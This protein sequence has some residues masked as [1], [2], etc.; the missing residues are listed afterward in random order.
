MSAATINLGRKDWL[1]YAA[2]HA[3]KTEGALNFFRA[4]ENVLSYAPSLFSQQSTLD[5]LSQLRS[6]ADLLGAALSFP[7]LFKN[8]RDLRNHFSAWT[9]A[10]PEEGCHTFNKVVQEGFNTINTA[11]Q[12]TFFL[13]SAKVVDLGAFFPVLNGILQG[14]TILT[15]GWDLIEQIGETSVDELSAQLKMFRIA[16]FTSSVAIA[17]ILLI[18]I[19]YAAL[20]ESLVFVLLIASSIFVVASILS[21]IWKQMVDEQ[22]ALVKI[23]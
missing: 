21:S 4:A 8:I 22:S 10:K 15:D 3:M 12:G 2:D 9:E 19:F 5:T 7:T 20:A 6:G 1:E 18:S 13:H 16:K 14:T 23:K 17:V 11:S